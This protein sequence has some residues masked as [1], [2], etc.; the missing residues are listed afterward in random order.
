[1]RILQN[2]NQKMKL[3]IEIGLLVN[4]EEIDIQVDI[5]QDSILLR[6]LKDKKI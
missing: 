5:D 4:N 3:F 2:N 6:L 1:M